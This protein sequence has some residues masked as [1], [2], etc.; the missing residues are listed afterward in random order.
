MPT[1]TIT[2]TLTQE[3]QTQLCDALVLRAETLETNVPG[4]D[5]SI[6]MNEVAACLIDQLG[7]P[8]PAWL[9]D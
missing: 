8:V 4:S 9:A 3:Q 7:Y 6:A 2:M 1:T 5:R